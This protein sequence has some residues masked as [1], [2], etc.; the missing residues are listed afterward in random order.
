MV[1]QMINTGE[2]YLFLYGLNTKN[3][4]VFR[5]SQNFRY[6]QN[7]VYTI[8]DDMCYVSFYNFNKGY[9][10]RLEII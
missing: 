5:S 4:I 2:H 7:D 6:L 1:I 3:E 10:D 8:K 9:L